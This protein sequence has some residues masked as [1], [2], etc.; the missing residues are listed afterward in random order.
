MKTKTVDLSHLDT[1]AHAHYCQ[2]EQQQDKRIYTCR[3]FS[4]CCAI[5]RAIRNREESEAI[6]IR[7]GVG[8]HYVVRHPLPLTVWL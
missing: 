8:S 4:G 7:Q 2:I 5:Y 6:E 1:V 3:T